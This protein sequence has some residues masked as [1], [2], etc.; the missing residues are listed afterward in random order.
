MITLPRT[1]AARR[2]GFTL[3]ELLQAIAILAIL[4]GLLGPMIEHVRQAALK[5]QIRRDLVVINA[6]MRLYYL[7]SPDLRYPFP[8]SLSDPKLQ[9]LIR[10][11]EYES[12]H[13]NDSHIYYENALGY[14]HQSVMDQPEIRKPHSAVLDRVR[15]S[16]AHADAVPYFILSVRPGPENLTAHA[17]HGFDYRLAGGVRLNPTRPENAALY[18]ADVADSSEV[19]TPDHEYLGCQLTPTYCLVPEEPAWAW[20]VAVNRV[21][22]P[23]LSPRFDIGQLALTVRAAE[24]VVPVLEANPQLIPQVRAYVVNPTNIAFLLNKIDP[25]WDLGIPY[26]D[27]VGGYA[28]P[29]ADLLGFGAYD[30]DPDTLPLVTVDPEADPGYL[31][32]PEA[33]RHLIVFYFDKPGHVRAGIEMMDAVEEAEGRGNLNAKAGQLRAFRNFVN[34]QEG[35][36]LSPWGARVLRVMSLTL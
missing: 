22:A 5:E 17:A 9:D 29:F 10:T 2:Q 13:D 1:P 26:R 25:D 4:I 35:K 33:M 27:L 21:P 34:A 6:A 16:E 3:I 30:V 31:F 11:A 23:R 36:S 20:N 19:V 28:A 15:N 7:D 32:S 14:Y 8:A 24:L 12:L 18:K